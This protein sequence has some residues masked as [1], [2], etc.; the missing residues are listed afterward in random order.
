MREIPIRG[1]TIRLGQLLK[2]AGVVASGAEAKAILADEAHQP[3][4]N[5]DPESRRGRQLHDGDHVRVAGEDLRIVAAQTRSPASSGSAHTEPAA[6]TDRHPAP[7]TGGAS[8]R[9]ALAPAPPPASGVH[10][11]LVIAHR[12]AWDPAPQNSLAAFERAIELGADGVEL[13]VRRSGDDRLVIVHDARIGASPVSRLTA[14]QLRA[15]LAPGQAP[16]LEDVLTALAPHRTLVDIE[17]K[18]D[19][20]VAETMA[21][22]A[23]HLT[24]D[25]YVIT[26]FL[27]PV[28]SQVRAAVPQAR[29]GLLLAARRPA[30]MLERR[31]QQSGVDFL[32]LHTALARTGLLDFCARRGLPAW[33]WT[34]NDPRLV[35]TL[36][37]DPR[38][39]AV[40]TD[41]TRDTVAQAAGS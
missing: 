8:E 30:R 14:A 26:S 38:V 33:V 18:E 40:I 6:D 10:R 27:D 15:R 16:E 21:A 34:A 11:P 36:L 5:G 28:L 3:L 4:V 9:L 20:Y 19:G 1:E 37:A 32:A 17:L 13:D 35:R 22:V 23:R 41:R 12:G 39:E 2:L 24:P 31:V 25:R 7:P 29:T